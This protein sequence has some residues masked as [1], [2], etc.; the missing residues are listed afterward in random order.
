VKRLTGPFAVRHNVS[1]R[2]SFVGVAMLLAVACSKPAPPVAR[3]LQIE[4]LT[5][6]AVEPSLAPQ[7]TVT[8]ERALV[9]W[10]ETQGRTALLKFAERTAAGWSEPGTAASG[11]NWFTNWADA[12]SVFRAD[13]G[14]LIA[15]WLETTDVT[16]EAYDLRLS[17]SKDDGRTWSAPI[18]PHRDGTK[19]QHGFASPF[20]VPGGGFGLVWLDGRAMAEQ[21]EKRTDNMSLRSAIF[22]GD[23]KELNESLVDDRVCDC[24]PTAVA[25]AD[26]GP[27]VVFRDRSGDEVRDISVARLVDAR[28][29]AWSAP[30]TVHDDGWKIEACPVNGP[31]IAARGR[32][33]A[34]AWMTVQDDRGQAFVAFS[35]DA[36]TTFGA[37]IRLDEEASQGRVGIALMADGSAVASWLEFANQRTELRTR[38]VEPSGTRRPARTVAGLAGGRASGYPRLVRRG[39]EVL[40]AWTETGDGRSKVR[41]ASVR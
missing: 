29:G 3:E 31:A 30:R 1:M 18:S 39:D 11:D 40:L 13:G 4:P 32:E 6:E 14:M 28:R 15:Q 41:T 24:C 12:P 33:V 22:D 20:Q 35:N 25:A 27:L 2:R 17:M 8:G 36:G 10:I 37:P 21:G 23:G 9:S 26:G 19:T 34:V 16:S 7:L 5:L 38:S